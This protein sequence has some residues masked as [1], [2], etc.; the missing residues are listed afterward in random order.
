MC[1]LG[2]VSVNF[3]DK[4]LVDVS[5]RVEGLDVSGI[6]EVGNRVTLEV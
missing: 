2:F 5:D 1:D 4:V 6:G 3:V